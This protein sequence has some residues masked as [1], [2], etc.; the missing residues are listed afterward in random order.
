MCTII[1][2]HVIYLF[3]EV[4]NGSYFQLGFNKCSF[5]TGRDVLWSDIVTICLP[6]TSYYLKSSRCHEKA[7]WSFLYAILNNW[8]V[9]NKSNTDENHI[10]SRTRW[11]TVALTYILRWILA[12]AVRSVWECKCTASCGGELRTGDWPRYRGK[13]FLRQIFL[14]GTSS[15]DRPQLNKC[16][17]YWK[18]QMVADSGW[19]TF[20]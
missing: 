17:L 13:L 15:T 20:T 4:Q 12:K 2:I 19:S 10:K 14:G 18:E 6:H 1:L 7:T 9:S 8:F 11:Q 3:L 16:A 5:W